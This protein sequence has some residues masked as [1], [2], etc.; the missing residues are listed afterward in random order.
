MLVFLTSKV[1]RNSHIGVVSHL[2]PVER[3]GR[4]PEAVNHPEQL[5][6]HDVLGSDPADPGKVG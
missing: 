3:Y 2:T 4:K 6:Y 5:I 1:C